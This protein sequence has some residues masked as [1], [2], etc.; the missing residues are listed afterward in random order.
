LSLDRCGF[1]TSWEPPHAT[2]RQSESDGICASISDQADG[3]SLEAHY[4]GEL[5]PL[6]ERAAG[7]ILKAAVIQMERCSR[8]AWQF[9]SAGEKESAERMNS[10]GAG[11]TYGQ[12]SEKARAQRADIERVARLPYNILITGETGTG[13][14]RS[15]REIHGLSARSTRPFMELNCANLPEQLVE[16]EL[17]GYR[18]GAF[19]GADRDRKGLFEESDGGTLFLDEIG[20]IPPSVQN[21][22]LKAIDEK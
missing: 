13:K 19:T 22:L 21:K 14:T 12:M 3:F 15:A 10:I 7:A 17:F 5:N 9:D 8:R 20:D 18:K 16:A 2:G 4:R 11:S 6:S 1:I